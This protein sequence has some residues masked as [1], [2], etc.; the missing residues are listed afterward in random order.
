MRQLVAHYLRG[1][2]LETLLRAE[3]GHFPEL[4]QHILREGR[5]ARWA[6]HKLNQHG[7]DLKERLALCGQA[8]ERDWVSLATMKSEHCLFLNSKDKISRFM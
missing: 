5:L 7:Q 6:A 4:V 3:V 1:E 2:P 8:A